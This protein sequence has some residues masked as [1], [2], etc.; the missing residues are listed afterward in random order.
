MNCT[1]NLLWKGNGY[2]FTKLSM[3]EEIKIEFM[4]DHGKISS[5]IGNV[6]IKMRDLSLNS[7]IQ[8]IY[9]T[10]LI[11]QNDIVADLIIGYQVV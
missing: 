5:I 10:F 3:N 1:N 4:N 2:L 7:T 11:N 9:K 8:S 6:K